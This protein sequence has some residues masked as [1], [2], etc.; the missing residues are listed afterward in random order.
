MHPLKAVC[1]G[2][3]LGLFSLQFSLPWLDYQIDLY[4]V[5]LLSLPLLFPLRGLWRDR[6]YTYRW[7]GF[8]TLIYFCIGISEWMANP[9]LAHYGLGTTICSI[10][11]FLASIY[12]ARLLGIRNQRY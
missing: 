5:L 6:L 1:L 9:D 8:M 4:W 11:L 12:Y 7:T 3:W 2:S 10:L